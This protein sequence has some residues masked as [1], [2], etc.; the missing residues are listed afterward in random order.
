[1]ILSIRPNH[2]TIVEDATAYT[3][4]QIDVTEHVPP[5]ATRFSVLAS[6]DVYGA[7]GTIAALYLKVA[8]SAMDDTSFLHRLQTVAHAL[9]TIGING[10]ALVV[11]PNVGRNLWFQTSNADSA[12][13]LVHGFAMPNGD[14]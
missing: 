7:V 10:N 11:L 5:N 14:I 3:P 9:N 6:V 1:V 13:L 8:N 4:T 12:D 2:D